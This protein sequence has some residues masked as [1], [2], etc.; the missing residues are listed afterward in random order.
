MGKES[1]HLGACGLGPTKLICPINTLSNC[2]NS[3]IFVFLKNLPAGKTLGSFFIVTVPVPILGLSLSIVANLNSLNISLFLPTRSW[4]K[5]IS[6]SPENFRNNTMGIS[7]GEST[8][9]ARPES[10]TSKNRINITSSDRDIYR[11]LY[12]QTRVISQKTSLRSPVYPSY[13]Y[14]STLERRKKN[15]LIFDYRK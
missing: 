2:G 9:S 3:L 5:K 11:S 13:L 10:T 14:L 8:I 12:E 15:H 4:R 1:K 7:K 6:P